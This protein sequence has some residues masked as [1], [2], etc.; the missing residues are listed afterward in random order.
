[1][2][3]IAEQFLCRQFE[4]GRCSWHPWSRNKI[5]VCHSFLYIWKIYYVLFFWTCTK[6]TQ[7]WWLWM[8]NSIF[9]VIKYSNINESSKHS[10][11]CTCTSY[12]EYENCSI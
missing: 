10:G 1:M 11:R 4:V 3:G 6:N 5:R 8:L 12:K 2:L 9:S 7:M